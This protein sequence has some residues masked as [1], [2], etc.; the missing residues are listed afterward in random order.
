MIDIP[1]DVCNDAFDKELKR[2]SVVKTLFR[3]PDGTEKFKHLII[4][5]SDIA[6]DPIVF[7]LTTSQL[8]FYDKHPQF[9]RDIIRI[10]A[11]K[12]KFFPK[13]TVINCR[14]A[15]DLPMR[16][17]KSNFVKNRLRFEG[18]LPTDIL[19]DIDDIISNSFYISPAYKKLILGK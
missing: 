18:D 5:N 14:E 16:V 19:Q 11:Q 15:A 4:L 17:I 7:V 2:G 13:E 6:K 1:D 3:F 12:I 10:P 9:N 8:D